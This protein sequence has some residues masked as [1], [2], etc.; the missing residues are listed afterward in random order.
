MGRLNEQRVT[1]RR[2]Q[3][4]VGVSLGRPAKVLRD[5]TSATMDAFRGTNTAASGFRAA[6]VSSPIF[7]IECLQMLFDKNVNR[8][9]HSYESIDLKFCF[10]SRRFKSNLQMTHLAV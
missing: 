7:R 5:N 10:R 2:Q 9:P 8:F 1:L 4:I 6:L 3:G